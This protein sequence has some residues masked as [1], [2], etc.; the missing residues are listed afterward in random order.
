M[1]F[2]KFRGILFLNF[3]AE[4]PHIEIMAMDSDFKISVFQKFRI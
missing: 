3:I 1:N 2:M 4:I